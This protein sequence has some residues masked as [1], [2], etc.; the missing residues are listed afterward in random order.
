M[1]FAIEGSIDSDTVALSPPVLTLLDAPDDQAADL[2]V[3]TGGELV[4]DAVDLQ[5]HRDAAVEGTDVLREGQPDQQRDHQDEREALE[6][7][8][9]DRHPATRT[10]VDV[11]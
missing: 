7:L 2:D 5:R 10:D 9:G 8:S 11:P 3:A 1:R 6:G 4:A